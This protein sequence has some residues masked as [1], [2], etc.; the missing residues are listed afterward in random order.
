MPVHRAGAYVGGGSLGLG[1]EELPMEHMREN[2]VDLAICG[3][4]TGWTLVP[5]IR[6]CQAVGIQ[7]AMLILGHEKSEEMGI[8]YLGGWLKDITGNIPIHFVDSGEPFH[9]LTYGK[10]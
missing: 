10:M 6:D 5:Y 3:D 7:K 2:G 8:E 1:V 4:I 9:Y